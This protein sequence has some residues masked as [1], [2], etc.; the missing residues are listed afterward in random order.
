M[1]VLPETAIFYG[2]TREKRVE[3]VIREGGGGG[4]REGRG[5]W[6]RRGWEGGGNWERM[7]RELGETG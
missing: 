5:N 4:E 6:E 7:R 1:H 3:N 2:K